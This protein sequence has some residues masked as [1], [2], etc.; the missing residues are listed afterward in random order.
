[1]DSHNTFLVETFWYF[2]IRYIFVNWVFAITSNISRHC[3]INTGNIGRQNRSFH[4]YPLPV[5][6]LVCTLNEFTK[7]YWYN[8]SDTFPLPCIEA[9]SLISFHKAT[10]KALPFSSR[11]SLPQP[12]LTFSV[13]AA[14][15]FSPLP[16]P[17][18]HGM[19]SWILTSLSFLISCNST[20]TFLLLP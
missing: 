7:I 18:V 8:Q 16:V 9:Q 5:D 4:C 12:A 1:M 11:F 6:L 17:A 3:V 13:H 19:L 20:V 14:P 2:L 10:P 15:I